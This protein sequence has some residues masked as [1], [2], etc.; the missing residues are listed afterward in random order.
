MEH[1]QTPTIQ[2]VAR[3]AGVSTGTVSRVLNQRPGVHPETRTRVLEV[4]Q[5]LGYVPMQAARELTGKGDTVG[6]LLAPGVRRYI[7]YF[8]LLFEHLSEALWQAGLRL[9][10]T[11]TDP[12]GL[13]LKPAKGYI[14][15]GAHDHD[16]R[17]EA[18]AQARTPHVLVGVYPGAFWVA[19]D[20]EGGAYAATRHLLELGHREIAHL[21]GQPQHQAGRERLRG[22][23][24]ALEAYQVPY[25]PELVLDGDFSTLT[26]YRVVRKAW[27]G[28]LRFSALFAASDEM[29]VGAQA[30]LEDVGQ[31]VP[32]D[33]SLVGYD[34]L[35]EVG[36]QLTTV[37]QEIA[38]IARTTARLLKEA[39]AGVPPYGVRVPVRLVVRGTTCLKEVGG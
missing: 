22:Y 29:A 1:Q 36:E 10:E 33:V 20:D 27:E 18:L 19:P 28:G 8:V 4:V 37:R 12:A 14:L 3:L 39:L 23:R 16:P 31:R 17:L 21:T 34:D 30:A 26:A 32:Q 6:I 2:D 7:P 35:P 15:L 38:E 9:E 24:R 13:P 25:R 5:R 11:S